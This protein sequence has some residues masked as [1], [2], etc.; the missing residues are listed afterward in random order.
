MHHHLAI[1]Y[2]SYL[3]EVVSGRKTVECR[4]GKMGYPP[5]GAV[6]PGD[7]I[8]FKETSGPVRVV[9]SAQSIRCF[10]DVTP[11]MV[12]TIRRQW[13]REIRASADFWQRGR[14]MGAEAVTLIWLGNVCPLRPFRVE[15]RNRRA[16]VV[17]AEAPAPGQAVVA[18]R[19]QEALS[20]LRG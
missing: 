19:E 1:L 12:E 16:W 6:R 11:A 14:Q 2:G 5:H 18:R 15:K 3:D 13:G 7:L 4:L 17:L 20:G 10:R 9:A 8:W